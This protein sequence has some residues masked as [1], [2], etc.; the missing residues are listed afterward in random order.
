[1][2]RGSDESM[3][4][5]PGIDIP[6]AS[7]MRSKYGTYPE[8]HTSADLPLTVVTEKGLSESLEVHKCIVEIIEKNVVPLALVLGEPQLGR[9][10]LYPMLSVKGSTSIV[11]NMLNL[12]SYA[13]GKLNLLE[14]AEKCETPIWTLYEEIE[15]LVDAGILSTNNE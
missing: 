8:Y 15:K 9:R 11:K 2:D 7:I 13:D 1:L 5:A 4:C 3:F 6:M 14:I 10:G 12:I